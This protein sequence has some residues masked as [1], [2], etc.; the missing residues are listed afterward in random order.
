MMKLPDETFLQVIAASAWPIL[1]LTAFNPQSEIE[2]PK[3]A[4]A[5]NPQS[6]IQNLKSK[7]PWLPPR[8]PSTIANPQ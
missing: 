5:F 4:T 8:F 2:N 6:Q 7:I 1:H 3:D